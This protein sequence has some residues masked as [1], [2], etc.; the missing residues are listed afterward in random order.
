MG[1]NGASGDLD[2]FC[3]RNSF[4]RAAEKKLGKIFFG[5]Q[6]FVEIFPGRGRVAGK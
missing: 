5:Q 3:I 6:I 4:S 1:N 2:N